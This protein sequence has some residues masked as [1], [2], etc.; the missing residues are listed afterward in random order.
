[1][2]KYKDES[3]LL[4]REIQELTGETLDIV[5]GGGWSDARDGKFGGKDQGNRDAAR[6]AKE[7]AR[8]N[9]CYADL[10]E[11]FSQGLNSPLGYQGGIPFA[12]GM[13]GAK[14]A[15]DNSP[16]CNRRGGRQEGFSGRK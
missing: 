8:E 5:S 15:A 6:D 9:R 11:G 3:C 13:A 14:V 4:D 10:A 7:R 2:Q 12:A 1:M 16:N